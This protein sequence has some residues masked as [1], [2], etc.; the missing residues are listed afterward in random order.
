MSFLGARYPEFRRQLW[1]RNWDEQQLD[2][3][4]NLD[5]VKNSPI[6]S[7]TPEIRD[8][9]RW[10]IGLSALIVIS[11]VGCARQSY[12]G[13][14]HPTHFGTAI[15]GTNT[16]A[17]QTW[18]RSLF[19]TPT[20]VADQCGQPSSQWLTGSSKSDSEYAI[21]QTHIQYTAL[22][23]DVTVSRY[24][25]AR[26]EADRSWFFSGIYSLNSEKAYREAEAAK[27]FSCISNQVKAWYSYPVL[28]K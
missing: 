4:V 27:Q 25:N 8:S 13:N 6:G 28:D 10:C 20:Q 7:S 24:P 5:S 15:S 26:R 2:A 18:K 22:R 19:L 1:A 21:I 16:T 12:H 23:A 11:T 3:I 14:D 17:N 9:R